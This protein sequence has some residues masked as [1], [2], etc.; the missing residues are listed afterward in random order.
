MKKLCD[1]HTHSTASDGSLT[2]TE[3]V[4][5]AKQTGLAA[6]VLSDH[7]TVEGLPE[8]LAAGE[9]YGVET[10]PAVEFS[11]EFEGIELHIIA[12]FVEPEYYG[13]ITE[14]MDDFKIRKEKS[15]IDLI[16]KLCAMGYELNY[17]EIQKENVNGRINRAHIA[18]ALVKGGYVSSVPEAFESLLDEK[19]GIYT[20]PKRLSLADGIRFLRNIE[21]VPVLAHPLK[22]ID[23][24]SLRKMLPEMIEAGLIGIETMH[25]SYDEEKIALSK[26]IAREYGLLESG[27][28]DFHGRF[29]PGVSLGVGRGNL[30]I[31]EQI[32]YNLLEAKNR[33]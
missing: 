9:K 25:S 29:K 17:S 22:E 5:L 12:M 23:G 4:A 16:D 15:N 24:D 27:G 20:P 18:S 7:N 3:L 10:V 11:T 21:A 2:P 8:F 14:R 13:V 33:L 31:N 19:C 30:A 28:S 32:Y 6:I 1:L 26:E